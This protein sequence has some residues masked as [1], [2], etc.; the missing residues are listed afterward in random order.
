[1]QKTYHGKALDRLRESLVVVLK[2][3]GFVDLVVLL[4]AATLVSLMF[5]YVFE[6]PWIARVC[7]LVGLVVGSPFAGGILGSGTR[8]GPSNVSPNAPEQ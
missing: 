2:W 3:I 6:L 8:R 4:T 7:A 5:D 1:M